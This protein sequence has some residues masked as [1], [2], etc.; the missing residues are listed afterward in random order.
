MT[1][2]HLLTFPADN[3]KP[4]E[5]VVFTAQFGGKRVDQ[6]GD[7]L[8]IGAAVGVVVCQNSRMLAFEGKE[9]FPGCFG[10]LCDRFLGWSGGKE[11]SSGGAGRWASDVE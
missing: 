7:G 3:C 8:A 9:A 6:G 4:E 11:S 5:V 2:V 1:S 10:V